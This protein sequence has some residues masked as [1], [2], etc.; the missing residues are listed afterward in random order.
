[1]RSLTLPAR[2][3]YL[4]RTKGDSESTRFAENDDQGKTTL[5][6]AGFLLMVAGWMLVLA[7]VVLLRALPAQTGFA[8][9]GVAVEALG[10]VLVA[11]RRRTK[12]GEPA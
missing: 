6:L 12:L 1:M 2:N 10:F 7:A 5:R 11:R 3:Q 9:A 4:A 8:L